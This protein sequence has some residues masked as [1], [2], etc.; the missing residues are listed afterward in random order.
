MISF[1]SRLS[2]IDSVC[3]CVRW[4]WIWWG[5]MSGVFSNP[6]YDYKRVIRGKGYTFEAMNKN[7]AWL[8]RCV[9]DLHSTGSKVFEHWLQQGHFSMPPALKLF[10]SEKLCT[11]CSPEMCGL[12]P[13]GL[14]NVLRMFQVTSSQKPFSGHRNVWKKHLTQQKN[15]SSLFVLFC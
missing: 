8:Y 11:V 6:R 13:R 12:E 3:A 2:S 7:N 5:I 15:H 9:R 4:S 10:S 14:C 1:F